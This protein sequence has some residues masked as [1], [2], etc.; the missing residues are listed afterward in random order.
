MML[1]GSLLL[2]KQLRREADEEMNNE[3]KLIC[4]VKSAG[5][6]FPSHFLMVRLLFQIVTSPFFISRLRSQNIPALPPWITILFESHDMK[7]PS[8]VSPFFADVSAS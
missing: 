6:S 7:S 8:T 5:A 1:P 2:E 3:L 4:L